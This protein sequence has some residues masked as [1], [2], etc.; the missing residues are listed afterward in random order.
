M[1][2]GLEFD[3]YSDGEPG[4]RNWVTVG[5]KNNRQVDLGEQNGARRFPKNT[6]FWVGV[7]LGGMYWVLESVIHVVVFHEGTIRTQ[8][9]SSDPHE[10][11]KRLL[12][13]GL[14]VVFSLYAQ[15]GINVR[16]RTEKALATSEK[17]AIRRAAARPSTSRTSRSG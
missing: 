14:L 4:G 9:L 3:S 6:Y 12:V 10:L 8:L 7:L 11:W 13:A 15:H 16:R 5:F 17:K 1:A 2:T